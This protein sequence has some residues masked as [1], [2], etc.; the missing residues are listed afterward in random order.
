MKQINKLKVGKLRL[1]IQIKLINS[2]TSSQKF[3]AIAKALIR[4]SKVY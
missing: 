4:V 2:R 3:K 1:L